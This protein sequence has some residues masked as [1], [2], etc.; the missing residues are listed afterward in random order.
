[1]KAEEWKETMNAERCP[2]NDRQLLFNS[3]CIVPRA[4]FS[5]RA[6]LNLAL[7]GDGFLIVGVELDGGAGVRESLR[8]V[9]TFE[10]D[11]PQEDVRVYEFLIRPEERGLQGTDGA[12]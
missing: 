9:A 2:M 3:S 4:S 10:E 12:R 6:G 7:Q 8:A 11:A 1:M 5:F